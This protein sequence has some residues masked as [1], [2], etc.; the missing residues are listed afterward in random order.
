LQ[1]LTSAGHAAVNLT[2]ALSP[3]L[4]IVLSVGAAF[5]GLKGIQLAGFLGSKLTGGSLGTALVGG[6][7][8]LNAVGLSALTTQGPASLA[9]RALPPANITQSGQFLF[10]FAQRGLGSRVTQ[11]ARETA[12]NPLAQL[13]GVIAISALADAARDA[14]G[15]L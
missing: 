15:S 14:S 6:S 2:S 12:T 13:G 7:G 11:A 5:A 1:F 4:K 3:L 10:P 9:G 8:I